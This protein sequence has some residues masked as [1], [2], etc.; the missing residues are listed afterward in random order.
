MT[1]IIQ[2]ILYTEGFNTGTL[3]TDFGKATGPI[4]LIPES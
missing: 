4:I 2:A 1:R 3:D